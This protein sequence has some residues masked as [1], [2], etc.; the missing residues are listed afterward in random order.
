[1]GSLALFPWPSEPCLGTWLAYGCH[2][3]CSCARYLLRIGGQALFS[4]PE[5]DANL[6]AIANGLARP[7]QSELGDSAAAFAGPSLLALLA[8]APPAAIAPAIPALL[9]AIAGVPSLLLA[10]AASQRM[11]RFHSPKV[12]LHQNCVWALQPSWRWRRARL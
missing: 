12:N 10:A 11:P 9:T 4:G 6:A 5:A 7:L 2:T 3:H 8:A 1:M